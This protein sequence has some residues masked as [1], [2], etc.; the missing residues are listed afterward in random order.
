MNV[1]K[2]KQKEGKTY[3]NKLRTFWEDPTRCYKY[4]LACFKLLSL[5]YKNSNTSIGLTVHLM[6][7]P[8]AWY[9]HLLKKTVRNIGPNHLI[10]Y[11]SL[12]IICIII[13]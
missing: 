4:L 6:L 5:L 3:E 7:K 9:E 8:Y 12:L 13:R 1:G 11:F 10:V 2:S